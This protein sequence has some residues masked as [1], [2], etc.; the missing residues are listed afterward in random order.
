MK[1]LLIKYPD[2]FID[3]VKNSLKDNKFFLFFSRTNTVY[4]L[5]LFVNNKKN[6]W[7]NYKILT[8]KPV[9]FNIKFEKLLK[10]ENFDL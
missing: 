6:I 4:N 10:L 9:F 5:F 2:E 7:Q 3:S 8:F 1:N